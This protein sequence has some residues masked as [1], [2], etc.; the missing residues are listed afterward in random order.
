MIVISPV[1]SKYKDG[2]PVKLKTHLKVHNNLMIITKYFKVLN[3][4]YQH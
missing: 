2:I 1:K 3:I 4:S